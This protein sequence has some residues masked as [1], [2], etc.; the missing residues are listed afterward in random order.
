MGRF[1]GI[2]PLF[3]PVKLIVYTSSHLNNKTNMIHRCFKSEIIIPIGCYIVFSGLLVH[4]GSKTCVQSKG[5]YPF[6][7]RLFFTIAENNFNINICEMTHNLAKDF[8]QKNVSSI[9]HSKM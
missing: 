9:C 2:C 5:E 8:V 4:G 6:C 3:H 7:I 1:S